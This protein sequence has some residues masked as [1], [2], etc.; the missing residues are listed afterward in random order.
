MHSSQE[1]ACARQALGSSSIQTMEAVDSEAILRCDAL[2]APSG[3]VRHRAIVVARLV[4]RCS[5]PE[6]G[7]LKNTEL[8]LLQYF[9]LY[10]IMCQ[11]RTVV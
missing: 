5:R 1:H 2:L 4:L 3:R 8:M 10:L 9:L 6:A 11:H 7:T